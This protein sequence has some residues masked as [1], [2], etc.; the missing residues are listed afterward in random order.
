MFDP[1][2]TDMEAKLAEVQNR[3]ASLE[4]IMNTVKSCES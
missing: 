2:V 4:K 3:K 1:E